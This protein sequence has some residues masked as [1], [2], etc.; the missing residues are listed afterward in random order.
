MDAH[1]L[2]L[3]SLH[4]RWDKYKSELKTCRL[5][6]SEA[7]V[8]DFR[9]AA[10]R[11]LASLDLLRAVIRDPRIQKTRRILKDQLDDLDD[12]RN[13]QALLADMSEIIHEMPV[14]K[15][16]QEYLQHKGKNLLRKARKEI[17]S[18]KIESLSKRIKKLSQT[19]EALKQAD[20]DTSLFAAVDESYAIVNR[21][22]AM[23]DPSQPATIHHVRLAFK[24]FRYMIE[25]I[26]PILQ[27]VPADYLKR[28]HDYQ[29]AM[30][31]IQD[32]E[33]ALQELADFDETPPVNYD[34]KPA[35]TYYRERHVLALSRY[36]EDKGEIITFW[37]SA[38]DQPFPE[39]KK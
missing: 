36:I 31:D 34:P 35:N 7:A 33:V 39:E 5:E 6:F 17:R 10:R 29:T 12:L 4:T 16:Y 1:T 13:I 26:H 32:M 11:L 19:I 28:L 22:Y 14:L 23:V 37:R 18:V 15:P 21:R 8:H 9:V 20:L 24:K 3:D 25:V 38:P 27:N 30:G 2:L